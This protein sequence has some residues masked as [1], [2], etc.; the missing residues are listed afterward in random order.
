METL[1]LTT[2]QYRAVLKA[3]EHAWSGYVYTSFSFRHDR[4]IQMAV[5]FSSGG[6]RSYL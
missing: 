5:I 1:R 6:E 4:A 2:W 3:L